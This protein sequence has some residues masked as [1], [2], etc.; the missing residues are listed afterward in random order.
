M[1]PFQFMFVHMMKVV[2]LIMCERFEEQVFIST[3]RDTWAKPVSQC[4]YANIDVYACFPC[5]ESCPVSFIDTRDGSIYTQNNT[6]EE[7]QELI[8]QSFDMVYDHII[9]LSPYMYVRIESFIRVLKDFSSDCN[10]NH[11]L[12]DLRLNTQDLIPVCAFKGY[13]DGASVIDFERNPGI[14]LFGK[15]VIMHRLHAKGQ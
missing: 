9:V 2:F 3:I 11:C 4:K 5:N 13:D 6:I 10:K 8:K 14:D 1:P 12:I 15:A 7:V